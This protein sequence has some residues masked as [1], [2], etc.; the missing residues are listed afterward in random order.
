[1][2]RDATDGL[3]PRRRGRYHPRPSTQHALAA[4]DE[5]PRLDAAGGHAV[6]RWS[7][8]ATSPFRRVVAISLSPE[9][10]N[11]AATAAELRAE[12]DA[13]ADGVRGLVGGHL[14]WWCIF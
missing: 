14:L 12:D 4:Q 3:Q 1:L 6:S 13:L 5:T 7:H 10:I 2:A 8:L 9:L 11:D